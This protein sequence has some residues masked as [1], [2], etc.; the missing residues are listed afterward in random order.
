MGCMGAHAVVFEHL[1]G[2]PVIG[3][4]HAYPAGGRHRLDHPAEAAVDRLAGRDHGRDDP[5]VADHVG[6][7]E[8]DHRERVPVA[9][10]LDEAVG[11][12]QRRHLRLVVVAR[13]V[14]RGGHHQPRLAG[15]R[16]LA[17]AVEEVR[18][19]GVLLGLRHVQLA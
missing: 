2:I 11:Q 12:L 16:L 14:A 6:V 9:D 15:E 10:L 17:P 19:V 3:R 7:R 5:R 13:D 4:D 1:F 18:H 8:V